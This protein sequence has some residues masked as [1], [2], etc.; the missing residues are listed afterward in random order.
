MATPPAP[1]LWRALNIRAFFAHILHRNPSQPHLSD[2]LARD[3][4]LPQ[5][6]IY[7]HQLDWPSK[8]YRHPML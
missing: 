8:T 4:G 5:D 7:H 6:M 1:R 2:H 3:M